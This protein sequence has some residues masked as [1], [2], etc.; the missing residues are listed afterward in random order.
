MANV[1]YREVVKFSR[2]GPTIVSFLR[3]AEAQVR[4]SQPRWSRR[5]EGACFEPFVSLFQIASLSILI[6]TVG[7]AAA[8]SD[9]IIADREPR[10]L[11]RWNCARLGQSGTGNLPAARAMFSSM[12]V[13]FLKNGR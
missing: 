5:R 6:W 1:L 3:I 8:E 7:V 2:P 13:L 4:A 11:V 10:P 12:P 9:R